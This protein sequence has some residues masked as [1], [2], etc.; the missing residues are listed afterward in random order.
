MKSL[1]DQSYPCD[2]IVIVDNASNDNSWLEILR[3]VR[4]YHFNN[5]RAIRNHKNLGYMEGNNVG[6][7]NSVGEYLAFLNVDTHISPNWLKEI[8]SA[9]KDEVAIVGSKLLLE[10]GATQT[11]GLAFDHFG[12][13]LLI[14]D[15]GREIE[16]FAHSGAAFLIIRS[17]FNQ[18]GQFDDK[19][20]LYC[21]ELDLAW[22][23]RLAGYDVIVS[24][25]A[26]CYH[27]EKSGIGSWMKLYYYWRNRV[28]ILLKNYSL[29]NVV[30][31]MPGTIILII[32]GSIYLFVK[33]R[34]LSPIKV[35]YRALIW[36]LANL[37][38][39]LSARALTQRIR[40]V[41][42]DVILG[43]MIRYPIEIVRRNIFLQYF[44][45]MSKNSQTFL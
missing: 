8:L 20:F 36:N 7:K 9:I 10:T 29:R 12:S 6:A 2:E 14:N 44:Q 24:S 34:T 45:R 18:L 11:I 15:Y 35:V 30:Y 26:V 25:D 19:L 28:R 43:K 1:I 13:V 4:K 38:D 16:A 33:L 41:D 17:V 40:R 23:V 39:T 32:L 42:D 31:H 22:R 27:N 21:D 37:R 3:L 5:I